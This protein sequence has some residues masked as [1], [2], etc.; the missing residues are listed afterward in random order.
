MISF[1]RTV[2]GWT[3]QRRR[4]KLRFVVGGVSI[5]ATF[6]GALLLACSAF[7][8]GEGSSSGALPDGGRGGENDAT[9]DRGPANDTPDS[10][11]GGDAGDMVD[12][13]LFAID[14]YE[15]TNAQYNQ[16]LNALVGADASTYQTSQC[17]WKDSWSR[18]C[19]SSVVPNDPVACIDWCDAWAYCKWA[20]KR[21]CGKVGGGSVAPNNDRQDPLKSEWMFACGGVEDHP[22]P[23]GDQVVADRCQTTENSDTR[24]GGRGPV[25]VGS[26]IGCEGRLPGLFDMTGNVSEWEDNCDSTGVLPTDLCGV[27][28]GSYE[29][30][31]TSAVCR[32]ASGAKRGDISPE[33]GFRCCAN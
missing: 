11:P 31:S 26:R 32:Y 16:F 4:L 17:T 19:T 25:P 33:I 22:Y 7:S 8:S 28:G 21:L 6:F 27:R 3:D 29:S 12:A 14:R 9:G 18:K 2:R 15:V 20:G 13:G 10:A 24:D 23:Y 30:S 5:V 1:S